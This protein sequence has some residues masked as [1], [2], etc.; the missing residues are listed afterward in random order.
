MLY[1][2]THREKRQSFAVIPYNLILYIFFPGNW[3]RCRKKF[4]Q[5][6]EPLFI[7]FSVLS[8]NRDEKRCYFCADKSSQKPPRGGHMRRCLICCHPLDPHYEGRGLVYFVMPSR[9]ASQDG[10]PNCVGRYA[11]ISTLTCEFVQFKNRALIF[12]YFRVISQQ[13][14][15]ECYFCAD[16]SSQKPSGGRYMRL[17]FHFVSSKSHMIPTP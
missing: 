8:L 7:R 5:T 11:L 2:I 13:R 15:R 17:R 6:A 12:Y 4:C 3:F 1:F 14:W 10:F 16:K 9:R